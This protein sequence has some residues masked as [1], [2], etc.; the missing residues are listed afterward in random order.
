MGDAP[1]LRILELLKQGELCL[2]EMVAAATEKLLTVLDTIG[3][4]EASA[5]KWR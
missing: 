3:F 4:I 5:I 2:T 1:R